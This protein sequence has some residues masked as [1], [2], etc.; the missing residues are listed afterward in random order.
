MRVALSSRTAT[1]P[2][3]LAI[4]L[5]AGLLAGCAGGP[6]CSPP[7]TEDE[8]QRAFDQAD[9]ALGD[10]PEWIGDA[11]QPTRQN[12]AF[13]ACRGSG[14]PGSPL[15]G[16]AAVHIWAADDQFVGRVLVCVREA[17]C[18]GEAPRFDPFE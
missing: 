15:E 11:A 12:G 17:V 5:G 8:C 16:F 6:D 7:L 10:H 13:Q 2:A 4:T 9:T 3:V 1:R 18:D 14:C